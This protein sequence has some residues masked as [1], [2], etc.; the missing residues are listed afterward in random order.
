MSYTKVA[1]LTSDVTYKKIVEMDGASYGD[2]VVVMDDIPKHQ[3]NKYD[4]NRN[5][6]MTTEGEAIFQRPG[7]EPVTNIICVFRLMGKDGRVLKKETHLCLYKKYSPE[8]IQIAGDRLAAAQE[9]VDA[10]RGDEI[11]DQA[12]WDKYPSNH[13][14]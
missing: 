11:A 10:G 5:W 8:Q 9:A 7:M 14:E 3:W 12:F 1:S 4:G 13:N 6:Q 2:H